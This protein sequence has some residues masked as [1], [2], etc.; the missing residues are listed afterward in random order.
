MLP[1]YNEK[2][3]ARIIVPKILSQHPD[4]KI[5]A[6]DDKSPDGTG[7]ILD[8]LAQQYKD[9]IFVLHRQEKGRGTAGIAG[10]KKALEL[11]AE[12]IVEM[13]ADGSHDAIY[14]NDLVKIV[15]ED[16]YD[17]AI[18]SRYITGGGITDRGR[19]RNMTSD[20][21]NFYNQFFLGLHSIK[22]TSGGYKCY[23]KKVLEAVNLDTFVSSGY[24]IGAEMLYRANK[25]GFKMKEIPIVFHNRV[26]GK[27]KAGISE[28][29]K[30]IWTVFIIYL[31]NYQKNSK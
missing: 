19:W 22:D 14:L 9:R 30:Y 29:F 31:G 16:G 21:A 1:T 12:Y 6:V 25:K 24:S 15:A 10:F 18:G 2:D 4:I 3:N 17:V 11:G 27:S 13:D 8:E 7:E 20:I 28:Y 23:K 26:V 5:V